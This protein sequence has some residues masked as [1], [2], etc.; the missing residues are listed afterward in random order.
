MSLEKKLA[1]FGKSVDRVSSSIRAFLKKTIMNTVGSHDE[2]QRRRTSKKNNS[3]LAAPYTILLFDCF[4]A[5]LS[6]FISIHLRIGMD[7]LDY[8]PSYIIK[9]MFVF[10]L[11]CSSV[12]LWLQ[13]HQ[14][15]WRYTSIEDIISLFLAV[16]LSN[17]IFFPLMM[18]MNQEDFLPYSVLVIN[19]FV[20]SFMIITPRFVACTLYNHRMNTS[21]NNSEIHNLQKVHES[22]SAL[23]IGGSNAT[24]IF[25]REI[26][27]NDE[28]D[29]QFNPI[30][31]V[32]MDISEVG[33]TVK[34]LP[35]LGEIREL[36]LVMKSLKKEGIYPNHLII[37]DKNL[38]D[39]VKKHL[40]K[41]TQDNKLILMHVFY[42]YS[43]NTVTE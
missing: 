25:L 1:E 11:V 37:T 35:I 21:R 2:K 8:S 4:I 41:Y 26:V 24:E 5:F 19:V 43:F 10:C 13:T 28:L 38:Q 20:L 3:A 17:I 6:I 30:G 12:F 42:Q 36:H 39:S 22:P 16:V 7:F 15:F 14:S 40:L 23:L 33:R 18:L 9:N 31:I 34:G 29:F 32:S 27:M